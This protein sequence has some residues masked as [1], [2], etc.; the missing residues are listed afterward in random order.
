MT[1]PEKMNENF[2]KSPDVRERYL[3][4]F[5]NFRNN[6]IDDLPMERLMPG[7]ENYNLHKCRGNFFVGVAGL[8]DRAI[9]K[10]IITNPEAIMIGSDFM[11]YLR[12]RDFSKFSTQEDVDKVNRVLDYMIKELS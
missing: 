4:D 9:K 3:H 11:Q 10:G 8:I 5:L 12:E 6:F 1:P 7:D 2:E